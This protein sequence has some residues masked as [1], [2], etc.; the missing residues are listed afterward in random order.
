LVPALTWRDVRVFENGQRKRIAVFTTDPS[1]MSVALVIDQSVTFDT[2]EKINNSLQALQAAFTPYDEIAVFTYNNGVKETT[3]PNS[4][5][6]DGF[7]GAQTARF[8][9][10]LE[11]SKGRYSGSYALVA[12]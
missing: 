11:Q 12:S 8:G 7:L 10:L 5:S 1:P 6:K 3:P 2:M 9:A 4:L